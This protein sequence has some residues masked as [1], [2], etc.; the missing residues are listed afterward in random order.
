[1]TAAQILYESVAGDQ[2][3]CGA[4]GLKDVAERTD[5]APVRVRGV[6][7]LRGCVRVGQG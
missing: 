5:G 1:M 3:L 4:V 2:D 6:N 7:A